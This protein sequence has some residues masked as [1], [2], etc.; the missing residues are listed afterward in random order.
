MQKYRMPGSHGL[1]YR[2]VL[3]AL[4]VDARV[5]PAPDE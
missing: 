2:S 5:K 4:G 1:R 3:S